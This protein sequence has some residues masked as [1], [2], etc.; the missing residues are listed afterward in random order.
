MSRSEIQPNARWAFARYRALDHLMPPKPGF[1]PFSAPIGT[2]ED[3]FHRY[4][5][6]ILDAYGVLNKGEDVI[7]SALE[8]I[9]R[10]R[11][12]GK[13]L[14]ILSNAATYTVEAAVQRFARWGFDFTMDEVL[15]SRQ[16]AAEEM[17]RRP[18]RWAAIAPAGARFDDLPGEVVALDAA[19]LD[20]AEGFV[21]LSSQE[22][23]AAQQAQLAEALRARPRP[24]LVANPDVVAPRETGFSWEPGHFAADLPGEKIWV[25]KPHRRAFELA[26][27]RLDLPAKRVAMVG[28]TLHTD[29]LGGKAAG[30]FTVMIAGHGFFAGVDPQP[31][32]AASGIIPDFIAATT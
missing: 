20:S 22:W 29:I 16:I 17:A 1:P 2:L 6:F 18:I 7:P 25:G 32:I 31:Y 3:V 8:R 23:D 24:V 27:A 13:R 19:A 9:A 30:C 5:G 15:T 4:D 28:D 10:M 11:A 21:F 12:A 26:L 14:V